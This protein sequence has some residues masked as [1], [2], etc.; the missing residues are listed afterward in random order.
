MPGLVQTKQGKEVT[1]IPG[2]LPCLS[3]CLS[4]CLSVCQIMVFSQTKYANFEP[5]ILLLLHI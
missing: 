2:E 3:L 5:I 1:V 4:V